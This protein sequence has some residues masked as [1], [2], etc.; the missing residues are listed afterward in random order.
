VSDEF[1]IMRAP[2]GSERV[3]KM[4]DLAALVEQGML[5]LG[6]TEEGREVYWVTERGREYVD[7]LKSRGGVRA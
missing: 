7:W 1:G 2:D 3:V 5:E 6:V 4:S